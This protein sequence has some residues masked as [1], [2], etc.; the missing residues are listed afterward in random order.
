MT[1]ERFCTSG[2]SA[3]P[4]NPAGFFIAEIRSPSFL[5]LRARS[6]FSRKTLRMKHIGRNSDVIS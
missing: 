6:L 2:L 1:K 3:K 4:G 5:H